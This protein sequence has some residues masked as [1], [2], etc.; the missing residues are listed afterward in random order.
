M[1]KIEM[2]K[3]VQKHVKYLEGQLINKFDILS[4]EYLSK[5]PHE[6]WHLTWSVGESEID[7]SFKI[8]AKNKNHE[9]VE[10]YAQTKSI[11]GWIFKVMYWQRIHG[12]I[13]RIKM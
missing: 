3:R 6:I 8:L 13:K 7:R 2:P 5:L 11:F 1:S 4:I 9:T 10:L 12:K